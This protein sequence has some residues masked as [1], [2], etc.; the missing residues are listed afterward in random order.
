ML[1]AGSC[2]PVDPTALIHPVS[3]GWSLATFSRPHSALA[4]VCYLVS[5]RLLR[6]LFGL[7]AGLLCTAHNAL[8]RALLLVSIRA[9]AG[10]VVYV[11]FGLLPFAILNSIQATSHK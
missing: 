5:K 1:G 7:R 2:G 4:A 11:R 10:L 8:H 6:E 3:A 9:R